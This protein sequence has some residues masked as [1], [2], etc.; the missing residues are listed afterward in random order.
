[1]MDREFPYIVQD[2]ASSS[3]L[4]NHNPDSIAKESAAQPIVRFPLSN[5]DRYDKTTRV[6]TVRP[7]LHFPAN[8][9]TQRLSLSALKKRIT[10]FV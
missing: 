5:A 10:I 7:V 4:H 8:R 1:M 6:A 3:P 9:A 2:F